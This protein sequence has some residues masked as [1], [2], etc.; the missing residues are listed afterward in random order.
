MRGGV[1]AALSPRCFRCVNKGLDGVVGSARSVG[2]R[3]RRAVYNNNTGAVTSQPSDS[4][5]GPMAAQL[6][7]QQH[8]IFGKRLHHLGMAVACAK[9]GRG[10][11]GRDF[12]WDFQ[13]VVQKQDNEFVGSLRLLAAISLGFI[14]L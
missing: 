13:F 8:A 11:G 9:E 2:G 3:G 14:F 5:A 10:R 1:A 6:R 4:S 7:H 12:R